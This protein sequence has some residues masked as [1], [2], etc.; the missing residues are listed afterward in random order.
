MKYRSIFLICAMVFAAIQIDAREVGG[1][2]YSFDTQENT[3]AVVRKEVGSY[4]GEIKIPATVTFGKQTYSV[5]AIGEGAFAQSSGLTAVSVPNSVKEIGD[6][7]FSKCENLSSVILLSGLNVIGREAF[8]Y[9]MNLTDIVLPNSVFRIQSDAF[10]GSGLFLN[11]F[12]WSDKALYVNE[13]LMTVNKG[14]E[15][16]FRVKKGTR[17]IAVGAF[18][19]ADHLSAV[20]LPGSVVSIGAMSGDIDSVI[21]E[22][23]IPPFIDAAVE[24]FPRNSRIFVPPY[25]LQYYKDTEWD[26]YTLGTIDINR[27]RT[28]LNTDI[29]DTCDAYN[30]LLQK[31]PY[32]DGSK[33][34]VEPIPASQTDLVKMHAAHDKVMPQIEAIFLK[35][36]RGGMVKRLQRNDPDKYIEIY[37]LLHHKVAVKMDSA[38]LENRCQPELTRKICLNI[39]ARKPVAAGT[40]RETQY[41]AYGNLFTSRQHFDKRYNAAKSNDDFI[42]EVKM[43]E[44]AKRALVEL[45]DLMQDH[46]KSFDFK[47]SIDKSENVG[48]ANGL[49]RE[50]KYYSMELNE[51]SYYDNAVNI[52]FRYSAQLVAEFKA[53]KLYFVSRQEFYEAF[54][55]KDYNKILK[56]RKKV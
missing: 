55:T 19:Q 29:K 50:L 27:V 6:Y 24:T 21:V 7:A 53:N 14:C 13:C 18:S 46:G 9:C 32:Y 41:K 39:I 8:S 49:A 52:L 54:V 28:L 25:A 5:T 4:K 31:N 45:E 48:K 51:S 23:R 35:L 17:I 12:N 44:K 43:R 20:V 33:I 47:G 3:A 11:S 40:C 16:H 15:K 38:L 56:Q 10:L 34:N 26:T 37:R 42:E 22:S 1:I 30:E 2:N 36:N